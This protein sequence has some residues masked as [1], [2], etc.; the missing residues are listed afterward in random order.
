MHSQ[1]GDTELRK[2]VEPS[3]TQQH[4]LLL[5]REEITVSDR[6][7][8]LSTYLQEQI[9][10]AI[11]ISA[12]DLDVE[13]SF[14]YLGI[15]SLIATK[16]RNRL[17]TGLEV[18]VPAVKFM[19]DFT[20]ASLAELL[21]EQLENAQSST[22]IPV[23]QAVDH[24]KSYPL[25]HGQQGLWFLYKLSPK[26]AAYNIALTARIRSQLNIP[27]WQRSL[28]ALIDRHPTLRTTFGQRDAEPFQEF[29]ED[30]E[31][32]FEEIDAAT[33]EWDKLTEKVIEAYQ[34]PF[35]LGRGPVL[36]V[37]LFT[38]SA[39]DYVLLLTI[40][41]IA[42]DGFS[43]GV[44]MDE[45]RLLYEAENTNRSISLPPIKWQY[46]DFV[47]WQREML[48][49]PVAENLWNYWQQQ[50]AGELPVL[51]LPTDRPR[52]SIQKSQGASHTFEVT[53]ELTGKL[54]KM[55][56]AQGATL[57]MTLLSAFQVLLRRYTGQED[58]IIG[59]P[60]E[61]RSQPEFALTVGFFI[62][63]VALRVNLAGNPTFC[64][65]LSQ[66]RRTVLGAI[67]HQDYPSPLLIE[68][69]QVNRD[70][71]LPGLF[72]ASFNLLKLE[73]MG[74]DY[75]LSVSMKT[76][77]REDWG[78]LRLEPFV[79]PQQEGQYD[80][81]LDIMETTQSLFGIF[82]YNT[83]LFDATTMARIAG[84]FQNLLAAIVSNP[85]Q[86]VGLLPLLSEREKQ[87]LIYDWN[88]TQTEYDLS[89]C[90][91]QLFEAQVEKTPD[92]IALVFEDEQLT[93]CELNTR[94][95]Q[96]AHHLQKLGVG[97]EV[98]VGICTERSLDMVVG[99]LGILKAGGAYVPLDPSYP[100]E[101]LAFILSD[102]QVP[103]LLTQQRLVEQ[104]PKHEARV[105]C[106]DREW[107]IIAQQSQGNPI[108]ISTTDNLAY[109]I[110]TSGSTGQPKGVF[111]LHRGAINRF[112]WMWQ[113]YPFVQG[114][115]C[116][117]KTSLNFVDSVWEI[118]G[119][120]IQG[121]PT[122]IVPD[123]VVKDPQKL[124]A[125]LECDRITRLV[126]VPSLLRVLLDAYK[127]LQL[128][129]PKLKLWISSGEALSTELLVQFRQ[130]LPDST[131]LNLYGSSEVSAD[132][133]CYSLSPHKPLLERVL[134]GRPIANTQ[135]YILD[136]RKQLI[137]VGVTGEL[138]IGG[139]GLARGY[140]NRPELTAEKFIPNPFIMEKGKREN[141][142][143]STIPASRLYKTGDLARYLP[144]GNIELLGR[145]D[146]QVK[147]RG[148]R[149]ELGEIETVLSTH[150][151]V[152][153]AVAIAHQEQAGNKYLVAYIVPHQ[154]SPGILELRN[155][156]KQK[157]PNYIVPSAFVMLEALPLTANGKV[158]RRALPAP[159]LEKNRLSEFIPPRTP[160]EEAIANI[161]ASVLGIKQVGVHD[162]FFELGGHSLSATQ[163]ISRL[164]Q[165][166]CVGGGELREFRDRGEYWQV[167]WTTSDGQHHSSAIDKDELTVISSGI[168]LSGYDRDFDLQSLVGVI[169]QQ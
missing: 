9:A 112:H 1:I 163:V 91:H 143:L 69:L 33:W 165:T 167:E 135:I 94:A 88:T 146:N 75:E 126:V 141:A 66:V 5:R 92:A 155:F 140:L 39:Q 64:E 162:N 56:K 136:A 11:G 149:I 159:D 102:S 152:R 121:I 80:V 60:I 47:Q 10:K 107:N 89:R 109:V 124:V 84:H 90:L 103:V 52:S 32:C 147:I 111:G 82:R 42:V 148:F 168:C 49:S 97:L 35:D 142:T 104:L 131:L 105:V 110:Y 54:R 132:V 120:L 116:C 98:L 108:S 118:F 133:T 14:K 125:T 16:L 100:Q 145:I 41:H 164:Q 18:D 129:L 169:E 79:I 59:S 58:I 114:D 101:R 6:V 127:D 99:L 161:F 144:D 156:L 95:N 21:S 77:A 30:Q 3:T 12:S 63:M 83:N 117:Q 153:E 154:E 48:A 151:Q 29:H 122:V 8:L 24:S 81:T 15:D 86:Q 67:A 134:I 28:Q 38:R 13:Q 106:L 51:K 93:Y 113:N 27:A 62:N 61:G 46:R 87:Q 40:H 26:S 96:L 160:T 57:Y 36:R 76:T 22:S 37:N 137:P 2:E 17:R 25:T 158:D 71:S 73:E 139:D 4:K 123:K 45:L 50:L 119:P 7:A 44:L 43:F 53:E 128:R 34:R 115:I 31:V 19:E 20:V 70:P 85:Q 157:L 74:A 130:N 68:R 65:L 23:T 150:P 78:G 138:Y 55:A 166:F 72:R